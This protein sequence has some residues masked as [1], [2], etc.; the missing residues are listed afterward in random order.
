MTAHELVEEFRTRGIHV[1]TAGRRIGTSPVGA[2][3]DRDRLLIRK[4]KADLIALL[5][6]PAERAVV[7]Q[8]QLDQ[9]ESEGRPG[10]PFFAVPGISAPPGCLSCGTP[11]PPKRAY[12]CSMCSAAVTMVLAGE[13]PEVS[14]T[15]S[16]CGMSA[17][18]AALTD[19]D[20]VLWCALCLHARAASQIEMR[21]VDQT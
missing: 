21:R 3:N 15:C 16:Q 2:I 1:R 17:P 11:P 12:R 8:D 5:S 19:Y 4:L 6:G 20:G 10:A 7:F 13:A 14:F 18:R 9:W